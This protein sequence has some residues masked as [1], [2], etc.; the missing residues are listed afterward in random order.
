LGPRSAP[1]RRTDD[2]GQLLEE[3]AVL[4][5][6]GHVESVPRAAH[7]ALMP[8]RLT[9]RVTV[10]VTAPRMTPGASCHARSPRG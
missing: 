1:T 6:H 4:L 7:P 8:R 3:A 5:A 2:E 9:G 10:L